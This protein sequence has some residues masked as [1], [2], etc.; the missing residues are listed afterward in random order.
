L[1]F[2]RK[3]VNWRSSSAS[4]V[5]VGSNPTAALVLVV[6]LT[7]FRFVGEQIKEAIMSKKQK[8]SKSEV[9]VVKCRMSKVVSI[10]TH[11]FETV[12]AM[13]AS[14]AAAMVISTSTH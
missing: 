12:W 4:G 10:I 9:R 1:L 11:F 13:G 7:A 5:G 6:L 2:V 3:Y 14:A 8:K